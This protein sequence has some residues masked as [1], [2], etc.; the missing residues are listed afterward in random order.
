MAKVPISCHNIYEQQY[1]MGLFL[2]RFYEGKGV[3]ANDVGAIDYLADIHLYDTFGLANLDV[4][5]ARRANRYDHT[6]AEHEMAQKQVRVVVAYRGWMLGCMAARCPAGPRWASGRWT[7]TW[8]APD[9]TVSISTRRSAGAGARTDAQRSKNLPRITARICECRSG[10]YRGEHLP[11]V[12]GTYNLDLT[13][14]MPF[15]QTPYAATFFFYPLEGQL[16]PAEQ[17]AVLQ[18]SIQPVGTNVH[19]DL[20]VNDQTVASR[21]SRTM[22]RAARRSCPGRCP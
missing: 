17:E 18:L 8:F 7:T 14:G 4:V 16:S 19:L 11:H 21:T 20:V 3:A 15:Y 10:L 6:V 1:Q 22:D 2:R 13:A 12:M 5:R 9:T